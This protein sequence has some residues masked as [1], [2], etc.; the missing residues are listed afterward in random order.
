MCAC[1]CI[2]VVTAV[3]K[4]CVSRQAVVCSME[5]VLVSSICHINISNI[6][7]NYN[8]VRLDFLCLRAYANR[9]LYLMNSETLLGRCSK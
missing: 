7:R 6:C 1:V 3:L 5:Q 9:R 2:Y 4:G 8:K